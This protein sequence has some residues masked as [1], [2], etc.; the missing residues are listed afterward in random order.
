[1]EKHTNPAGSRG[2]KVLL[3]APIEVATIGVPESVLD[4]AADTVI[5]EVTG[6]TNEIPLVPEGTLEQI[7]GE[8]TIDPERD[9]STFEGRPGAL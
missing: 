5:G 8:N 2:L 4:A 6:V 3:D 9:G 1:M 7:G